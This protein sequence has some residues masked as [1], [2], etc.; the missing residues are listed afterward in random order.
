MRLSPSP[1]REPG[2]EQGDDRQSS[3]PLP[4]PPPPPP[5]S[6]PP[7]PVSQLP[8]PA[9]DLSSLYPINP[10]PFKY[11]SGEPLTRLTVKT[12]GPLKRRELLEGRELQ[13]LEDIREDGK[14]PRGGWRPVIAARIEAWYMWNYQ[15][16]AADAKVYDHDQDPGVI[17]TRLQNAEARAY[18]KRDVAEDDRME[19]RQEEKDDGYG[20]DFRRRN[21][22]NHRLTVRTKHKRWST[23][24]K[25][26]LFKFRQTEL[27]KREKSGQKW[28]M[29]RVHDRSPIAEDCSAELEEE[30][31]RARRAR[32]QFEAE[33]AAGLLED[34]DEYGDDYDP[35]AEDY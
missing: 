4:S 5:A 19:L 24:W 22:P 7:K 17:Q 8:L 20:E 33:K 14:M 29:F 30:G 28:E 15:P 11:L 12:G 26:K 34:A 10:V 6:S 21:H 3:P 25:R 13:T 23:V 32:E 9:F 2:E 35:Y 31:E 16:N 1:E 18:Q 27:L